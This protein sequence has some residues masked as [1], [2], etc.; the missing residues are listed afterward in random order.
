MTEEQRHDQIQALVTEREGLVKR[1]LTDRVA[2]VDAELRRLAAEAKPKAD[3]A[4]RRG[5]D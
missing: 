3:R 5:D 4:T 1:G 2:Q